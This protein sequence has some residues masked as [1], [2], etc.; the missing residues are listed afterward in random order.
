MISVSSCVRGRNS[1]HLL[2]DD[3]SSAFMCEG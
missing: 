1:V 2:G 3:D